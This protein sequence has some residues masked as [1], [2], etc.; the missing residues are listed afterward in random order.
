MSTTE[1]LATGFGRNDV[2]GFLALR[3]GTGF[4]NRPAQRLD[5]SGEW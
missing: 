3:L 1:G 5:L 4:G 2:S